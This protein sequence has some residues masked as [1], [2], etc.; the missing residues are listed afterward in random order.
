MGDDGVLMTVLRSEVEETST[1]NVD[2][3]CVMALLHEYF[4][5]GIE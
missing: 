4:G 5:T 2:V 1:S 3:S